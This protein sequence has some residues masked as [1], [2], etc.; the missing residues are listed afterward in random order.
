MESRGRRLAWPSQEQDGASRRPFSAEREREIPPFVEPVAPPPAAFIAKVM[1]DFWAFVNGYE[2]GPDKL[3]D[4]LDIERNGFLRTKDVPKRLKKLGFQN[5][6]SIAVEQ[7]DNNRNGVLTAAQFRQD[8]VGLVSRIALMVERDQHVAKGTL[9]AP[10]ESALTK[11]KKE[12]DEMQVD[13]KAG[14]TPKAK[15]KAKV[16]A[17]AKSKSK[18]KAK[19]AAEA[20]A[21]AEA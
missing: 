16:K 4:T 8:T 2:G 18:A 1:E 10:V 12:K 15:A 20:A 21:A 5:K 14:G 13:S 19:K 7:L 17:K 6:G 9:T 11:K 3:F